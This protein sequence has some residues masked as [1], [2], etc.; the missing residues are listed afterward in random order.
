MDRYQDQEQGDV[1]VRPGRGQDLSAEAIA[2]DT[3]GQDVLYIA[4]REGVKVH[5]VDS[6]TED[7]DRYVVLP[8]VPRAGDIVYDDEDGSEDDYRVWKVT[9]V[10][11]YLKSGE[12]RVFVENDS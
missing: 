6:S 10:F 4:S 12:I 9:G 11:F 7:M 5:L 8:T 1:R 2:P 3:E